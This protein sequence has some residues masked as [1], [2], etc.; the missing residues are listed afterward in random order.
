VAAPATARI[1]EE[2]LELTTQLD[3]ARRLEAALTEEVAA[4]EQQHAALSRQVAAV[5]GQLERFTWQCS[6]AVAVLRPEYAKP[7]SLKREL[8]CAIF[9]GEALDERQT[10]LVSGALAGEDGPESRRG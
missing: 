1:T 10:A 9:A 8:V 3:E 5:K 7:P 4:L 2:I 6:A